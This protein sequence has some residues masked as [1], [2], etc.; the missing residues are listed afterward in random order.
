MKLEEAHK[1]IVD[2]NRGILEKPD[3]FVIEEKYEAVYETLFIDITDLV[4]GDLSVIDNIKNNPLVIKFEKKGENW[5]I[6]TVFG[7]GMFFAAEDLFG[8]ENTKS[9]VR[10]NYCHGNCMTAALIIDEISE[11]NNPVVL[12]G[13]TSFS[14]GKPVLHSVLAADMEEGRTIVDYTYNLA[15]SEDLFK[16]LYNFKVLNETKP[17]NIIKLI[18]LNKKYKECMLKSKNSGDDCGCYGAYFL[19]ANEDSLQYMMDVIEE[20]RN[21]DF[22]FLTE[23]DFQKKMKKLE[24]KLH[25]SIKV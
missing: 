18:H 19:L 11:G 5:F 9:F 7:K 15:M 10:L 20:K 17:M 16:K 21:D 24:M 2:D 22:P 6:D 23:E 4:D 13:V 1:Y 14:I 25:Q 12:T 3:Y 8:K